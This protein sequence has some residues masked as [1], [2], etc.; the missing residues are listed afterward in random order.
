MKW[1]SRKFFTLL[2]HWQ[3]WRIKLCHKFSNCI[4][5]YDIC[6]N[7]LLSL[8][9]CHLVYLE[10]GFNFQISVQS[11]TRLAGRGRDWGVRLTML[12]LF[13]QPHIIALQPS[14]RKS[15]TLFDGFRKLAL[16][17]CFKPRNLP[18]EKFTYWMVVAL[19]LCYFIRLRG[20]KEGQECAS[21]WPLEIFSISSG[22]RQMKSRR[23]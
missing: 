8:E 12:P 17:Y 10:L 22:E 6:G 7:E 11:H 16:L 4:Y 1:T 9:T 21:V 18:G 3:I 19:K 15:V 23:T 2:F 20:T 13:T 5:M 14:N